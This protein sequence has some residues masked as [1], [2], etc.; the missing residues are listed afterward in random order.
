M[1]TQ[2]YIDRAFGQPIW[3]NVKNGIITNFPHSGKMEDKLNEVYKSYPIEKFKEEFEA[4]MK[5]S[6][7][8]VN[9]HIYASILRQISSLNSVKL[10]WHNQ[11]GSILPIYTKEFY[12]VKIKE[13]EEKL[14]EA[15]VDLKVEGEMLL[16]TH[17]FNTKY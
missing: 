14:V 8:C 5:P 17:N 9:P 12:E 6:F 13:V 1:S 2:F 10:Y 4:R 7:H 3:I 15:R 16:E 11:K